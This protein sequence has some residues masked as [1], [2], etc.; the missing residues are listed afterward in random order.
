MTRLPTHLG[1]GAYLS[2]PD[3]GYGLVLTANHHDPERAS[4]AVYLDP[5]TEERLRR[6]LNERH[7]ARTRGEESR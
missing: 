2:V 7:E 6:I 4:D 1:D 3:H 5:S